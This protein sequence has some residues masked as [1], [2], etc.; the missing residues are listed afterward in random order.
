MK[1]TSAIKR[2]KNPQVKTKTINIKMAKTV[3]IKKF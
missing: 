2:T 3:N 1:D